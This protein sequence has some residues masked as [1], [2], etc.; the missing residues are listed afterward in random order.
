[1]AKKRNARHEAIREIVRS[2]RVKTQRELVESLKDRGFTCTQA[3]VS[4]DI[5]EMGLH[6]LP[7]G[8]YVLADDLHLQ[9]MVGDLVVSVRRS[10]QLVLIG[11]HPGSANAVTTAIDAAEL[12]GVLGSIA[13]DDTILVVCDGE[14]AAKT[15][16][17]SINRLRPEE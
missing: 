17:G 10:Q 6:K 1:M 16:A 13:G 11:T 4:R 9:R 14:E 8:I 5:G 3:T 15:F 2:K 7:E 12:P